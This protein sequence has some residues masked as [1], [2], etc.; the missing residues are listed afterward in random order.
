[1]QMR[2]RELLVVCLWDLAIWT[3]LYGRDNDCTW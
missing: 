2:V 3:V 1:M